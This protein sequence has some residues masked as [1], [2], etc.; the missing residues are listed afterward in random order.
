MIA[1][2][3]GKNGRNIHTLEAT[4]TVNIIIDE[5]TPS[6]LISS[7]NPLK[8][9]LAKATVSRL[10]SEKI[11]PTTIKE[12]YTHLQEKQNERWIQTAKE[13]CLL[14]TITPS[15]SS[16]IL[17]KLGQLSVKTSLGQN[18][19]AHSVEVAKLMAIIAQ[20]LGLRVEQA[21]LIGLFHDI[22]KAL[23]FE[24]GTSN[25]IAGSRFLQEEGMSDDIVNAI[26]SHHGEK[27]AH[28]EEAILLSICDK[29][30]AKLLGN[31][32]ENSFFSIAQTCENALQTIPGIQAWAEYAGQHIEL[33]IRT[34]EK[35]PIS[36]QIEEILSPLS[37]LPIRISWITEEKHA[38]SLIIPSKCADTA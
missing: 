2:I 9:E 20:E 34:K 21:K 4:C 33:I 8:R 36:K 32:S 17:L 27:Y 7:Y 13:Y 5:E 16:N 26:A 23:S 1:K 37:S 29:L 6:I 12:T 28:S 30:S 19:L 35:E 25:A 22:G 15:F 18:I 14:L 38:S 3:I 11:T 31:R 24:K 10:L